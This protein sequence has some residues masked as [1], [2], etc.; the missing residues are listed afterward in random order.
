VYLNPTLAQVIV[1]ERRRDF[2]RDA[3]RHLLAGPK[4]LR[5]A[6]RAPSKTV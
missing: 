6:R 3:C 4:R 2:E 1:S 5:K